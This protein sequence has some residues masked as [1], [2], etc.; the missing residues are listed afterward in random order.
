MLQHATA[1]QRPLGGE[2]IF[3]LE[4]EERLVQHPSIVQASVVGLPDPKYGEVVC[5]FLQPR[6]GEARPS[7]DK[8]R[9]FVRQVLGRHKAPVHAF[10]LEEEEDFPKTGSGKIQRYVLKEQAKQ[11]L[12]RGKVMS[13][14]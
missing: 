8:L 5:A 11:R 7:L 10:W 1:N 9:E 4:I 2:N 13:K 14:L 3:P 12:K 6:L